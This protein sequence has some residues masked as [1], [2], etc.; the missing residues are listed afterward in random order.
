MIVS[1]QEQIPAW[2][3]ACYGR[4]PHKVDI[5]RAQDWVQKA[6]RM[7]RR[8]AVREL[9]GR[10]FSVRTGDLSWPRPGGGVIRLR[11][12]LNL[13]GK[14]LIVDPQAE[15]DL[16]QSL[17]RMGF[18][19]SPSPREVILAHELFHLFCPKCPSAL[20]ELSAHLYA[21]ELLSLPY[22]PGLLDICE[23]FHQQ[24]A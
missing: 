23:R 4:P 19:V 21:A 1:V 2:Y 22:F 16:Q 7:T 17:E 6:L 10:G 5:D 12:K 14:E 11:A 3:F 18:P 20:A 15:V 24:T 13:R 8:P 9:E